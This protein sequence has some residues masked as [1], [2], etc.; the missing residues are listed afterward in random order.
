MLKKLMIIFVAAALLVFTLCACE[1]DL[2][3]AKKNT[4]NALNS[5]QE[6]QDSLNSA[7]DKEKS[8]IDDYKD[9]LEKLGK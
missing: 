4:S 9:A 6:N 7:V 5:L 1:S 8:L 2:E 3:K